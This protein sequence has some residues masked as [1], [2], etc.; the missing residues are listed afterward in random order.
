MPNVGHYTM[1]AVNPQLTV[2]DEISDSF[3]MCIIARNF[4][5]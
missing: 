4:G 1:V 2:E 3:Y 5:Q